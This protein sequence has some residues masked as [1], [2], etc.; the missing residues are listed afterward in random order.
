MDAEWDVRPKE[1]A[2]G[3]KEN[4][5]ES[6]PPDDRREIAGRQR[7]ANEGSRKRKDESEPED[8]EDD[9]EE[10]ENHERDAELGTQ[11][12]WRWGGGGARVYFRSK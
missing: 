10:E 9:D 8:R 7:K 5:T 3:K 4:E 6:R 1:R 2:Q 11:A 12:G